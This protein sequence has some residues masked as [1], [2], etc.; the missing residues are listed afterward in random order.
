MKRELTLYPESATILGELRPRVQDVWYNLSQD[1]IRQLYDRLHERMQACVAARG[2]TL[3][4][5]LIV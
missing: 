2:G 4:I 3:C 1:D 5:V